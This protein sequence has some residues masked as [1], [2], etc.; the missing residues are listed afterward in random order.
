MDV[1]IFKPPEQTSTME[2]SRKALMAILASQGE[3]NGLKRMQALARGIVDLV[4]YWLDVFSCQLTRAE[5]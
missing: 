2:M 4:A 5:W 1:P 3:D